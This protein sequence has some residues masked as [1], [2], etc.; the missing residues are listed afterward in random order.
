MDIEKSTVE[1]TTTTPEDTLSR[2][3]LIR[4]SDEIKS[5]RIL[6]NYKTKKG[7]FEAAQVKVSE[8]H[9]IGS[10]IKNVSESEV[11][12]EDGIYS[13]CPPE[14]LYYYIK[15]KKMKVVDQDELFFSNARLY[16]LDIPYPLIFPFGY[17]PTDIEKKRSGL[18]TPTYAFQN[19][20]NRGLGLQNVGWFQY[21]NDYLTGQVDGDIYTSGTFYLNGRVQYRKT[22][23]YNGSLDIGY[24]KDRGLEPTD[25]D[26]EERV[27]KSIGIQHNQTISPYASLTANVKP[28]NGGLPEKKLL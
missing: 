26:F 8:G 27:Q 22:N 7:K 3:V 5:T 16:I 10:K 15:A 6:F 19:Q 14:Y 4:D 23:W 21:F 13:T 9:L 25:P 12:I 28:A 20:N 11:F 2:P 18:L 1:A 24:S 17:V